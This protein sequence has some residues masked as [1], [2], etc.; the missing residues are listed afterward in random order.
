[1]F[2]DG[3]Y[4]GAVLDRNGLRPSRYY[5][6]HDD[7]VIMSSE[8]GVIDLKPEE[9]KSKGRLQPGRMF[10]VDFE[11]GRIIADEELKQSVASKNP[12]AEWLREQRITLKELIA[13][14][15]KQPHGFDPDTLIPRLKAFGYTLEH[16]NMLLQPMGAKGIEALGSMGNDSALA[17]L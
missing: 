2:S 17:V 5:I 11:E 3:H 4:I 12:Y 6:T 14:A 16:V 15:K 8:V 13:S 9:V 7:R 1:C 10:L